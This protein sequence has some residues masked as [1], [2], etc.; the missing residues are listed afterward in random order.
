MK[1]TALISNR[2]SGKSKIAVYE[3]LKNPETTLFVTTKK[4][5]LPKILEK[6]K[7][8]IGVEKFENKL[9]GSNIKRIIF[10]E[11]LSFSLKEKQNIQEG[12]FQFPMA[13]ELLIFSTPSKIYDKNL[14]NLVK[15]YKASNYD[16]KLKSI[17]LYDFK[18]SE[19]D[20]NELCASLITEP[21][22][23]I[24]HDEYFFNKDIMRD[25]S[26]ALIIGPEQTKKELL[27]QYLSE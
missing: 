26:R 23:Q 17:I 7:N 13:T 14:F 6:Q 20:L 24:I 8:G 18:Y 21:V 27:G 15:N 12:L 5:H 3:F 4:D 25:S 1:I 16:P 11:Y 22:C 9:R 2:Q 10:D 19:A